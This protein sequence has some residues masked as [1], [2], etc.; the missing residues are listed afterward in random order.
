MRLHPGNTSRCRALAGSL[1]FVLV[2]ACGGC[3]R[4]VSSDVAATVNGRPITYT[5]VDRLLATQ[6]PS[7]QVKANDDQTRELKLEML[8]TLIDAE[9][10]L[11]KAEKEGLQATDSDVDAKYNE[12]KAPYT[13]DEFKRQLTARHMT[14]T[15]FKAQLRR[16]LSIQKLLNKEIG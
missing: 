11:Q 2:A 3:K 12:L 5:E 6:V 16:D 10:M 7:T 1:C 8:R 15:D 4:T 13:Q 14:E 9:I